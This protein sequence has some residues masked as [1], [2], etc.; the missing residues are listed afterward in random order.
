M[1]R[2]RVLEMRET[3]DHYLML[4]RARNGEATV[5][6][7]GAGWTGSGDFSDVLRKARTVWVWELFRGSC[8]RMNRTGDPPAGRECPRKPAPEC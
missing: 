7:T 3:A 4:A 8:V 2:H 1:E 5:Q 6:Y